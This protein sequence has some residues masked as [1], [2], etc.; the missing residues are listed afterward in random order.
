MRRLAVVAVLLAGAGRLPVAARPGRGDR[1]L[2]TVGVAP[3]LF[4][5]RFDVKGCRAADRELARWD[6]RVAA[7]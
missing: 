7:P 3:V 4:A 6:V 2:E 1:N 5:T